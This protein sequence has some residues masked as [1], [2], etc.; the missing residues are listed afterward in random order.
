MRGCIQY[1]SRVDRQAPNA[2]M[3]DKEFNG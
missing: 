3:Y 1:A 2:P